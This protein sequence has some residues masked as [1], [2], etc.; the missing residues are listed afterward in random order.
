MAE[1]AGIVELLE[2]A[3]TSLPV[4][5]NHSP[6]YRAK[7]PRISLRDYILRLHSLMQCSPECFVLAR[8]YLDRI[9]AKCSIDENS[10]HR[11][12]LLSLVVAAK[13]Q[14]D[15]FCKNSHYAQVGG[16]SVEEL[17]ELETRFLQLL[18]YH[19]CVEEEV[20]TAYAERTRHTPITA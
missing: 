2:S 12:L 10:A 1:V 6:F 18:D 3:L 16:I 4:H 20:F 5:G 8:I 15:M 14:D 11:S 7:P 19:L 9:A 13:F 17:N